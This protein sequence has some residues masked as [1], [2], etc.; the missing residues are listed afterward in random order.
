MSINVRKHFF[1]I[2]SFVSL[3]FES[4]KSTFQNKA[5]SVMLSV[6]FWFGFSALLLCQMAIT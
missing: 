4:H 2:T 6:L 5:H 1:F 3:D